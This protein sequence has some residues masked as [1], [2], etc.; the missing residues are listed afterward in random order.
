MNGSQDNPLLQTV[1]TPGDERYQLRHSLSG[2]ISCVMAGVA[3]LCLCIGIFAH[4]QG[5]GFWLAVLIVSWSTMISCCLIGLGLAVHGII[6]RRRRKIF[7]LLGLLFNPAVVLM[8]VFYF[9]WPTPDSLIAATIDGDTHAI[10][11]ALSMGVSIHATST[12]DNDKILAGSNAMTAAVQT[13]RFDMVD[14]LLQRGASINTPDRNNGTPL[15]HAVVASHSNIAK[16]LLDRNADPNIPG[17]SGYPLQIAARQGH[18]AILELL[19]E[20]NAKV[21]PPGHSPLHEAAAL[22]HNGI[23]RLL[24]QAGAQ[25]NAKTEKG[26]TPLHAAARHGHI[27][28]LKLLLENHADTALTD[29]Q[30]LTALDMALEAG[31]QNIAQALLDADSPVDIF[32]A[33][34]MKDAP[35]VQRIITADPDTLKLHRKGL[36]PLH[37]AIRLK[38]PLMVKLLLANDADAN[39]PASDSLALTPLQLAVLGNDLPIVLQLLPHKPDV[40]RVIRQEHAIAPP[41]YFAVMHNNAPLVQLLLEHGADVNALC[42]TSEATARP[43]FFAVQINAIPVAQTLLDHNAQIDGRKN[44][45]SPTP[46]YEAVRLGYL[47]MVQFLLKNKANPQAKVGASSPLSLAE[48]QRNRD[49]LVYDRILSLL[50]GDESIPTTPAPAPTA[51]PATTP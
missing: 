20:H 50:K 5:N 37:D 44:E 7:P 17:P 41:L 49:P 35:R 16:Q 30:G 42:E 32:T 10:D 11:H 8:C 12:L 34:V 29:N 33:I 45:T 39:A 22:G 43:L 31:H 3:L 47:E 4:R 25:V 26:R 51:T 18:Q 46:L 40:N 2:V 15:Y 9:W 38:Q 28:V 14:Y 27:H 24:L 23:T 21:D 19:L 6:P 36:T 1:G 13:G 48:S